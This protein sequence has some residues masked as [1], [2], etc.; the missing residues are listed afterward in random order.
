MITMRASIVFSGMQSELGQSSYVQLD[1]FSVEHRLHNIGDECMKMNQHRLHNT[2][3][4]CI[5][6]NQHRLHNT[7]QECMKMNL[8]HWQLLNKLF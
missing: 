6:M 5:E 8:P 1:F 4:E 3:D 7:G 2:G